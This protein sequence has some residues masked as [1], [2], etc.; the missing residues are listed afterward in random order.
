V[1]ALQKWFIKN[2]M[3]QDEPV[4]DLDEQKSGKGPGHAKA[5]EPWDSDV[6]DDDD[7]YQSDERLQR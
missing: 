6:L 7:A 4:S 2:G 1:K 5:F 3:G